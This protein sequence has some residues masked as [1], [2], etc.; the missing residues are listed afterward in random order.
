MSAKSG[1]WKHPLQGLHC[2]WPK[3][4]LW[5][6]RHFST[7]LLISKNRAEWLLL[8]HW[9]CHFSHP[10]FCWL[11]PPDTQWK[12]KRCVGVGLID[13]GC[14]KRNKGD[15]NMPFWRLTQHFFKKPN[16]NSDF[17]LQLWLLDREP[18]L[19]C[20]WTGSVWVLKA[21]LSTLSGGLVMFK[22]VA[23]GVVFIVCTFFIPKVSEIHS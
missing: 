20:P 23:F 2:C 16:C 3:S 14:R 9:I 15:F 12:W 5:K 8:S 19:P 7:S 17:V 10:C 11:S 1:S 13:L 4:Y 18:C 22:F 21:A 6:F